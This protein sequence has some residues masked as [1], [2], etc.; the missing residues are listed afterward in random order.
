MDM[1]RSLLSNCV[2]KLYKIVNFKWSFDLHYVVFL[3][4]KSND[5][6]CQIIY[7]KRSYLFHRIVNGRLSLFLALPL[8]VRQGHRLQDLR[9][10]PFHSRNDSWLVTQGEF[11]QTQIFPIHTRYF[12]IQYSRTRLKRTL[13]DRSKMFVITVKKFINFFYLTALF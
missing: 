9:R 12:G 4:S 10:T 13:G 6:K 3:D 11:I 1:I 2:F 7:S 8:Q 5:W